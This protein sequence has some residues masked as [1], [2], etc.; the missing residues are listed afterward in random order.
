MPLA[1]SVAE[2]AHQ[3]GAHE[4]AHHAEED[5]EVEKEEKEEE[6]SISMV[7]NTTFLQQ[8]EGDR[9]QSSSSIGRP[10]KGWE[11][12]NDLG[13]EAAA[14]LASQN[15]YGSDYGDDY[16]EDNMDAMSAITEAPDYHDDSDAEDHI[17]E[18]TEEY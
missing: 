14:M 10:R 15:D 6:N 18:P 13:P 8:L 11:H 12:E 7:E 9:R 17:P 3:D 4:R 5:V 16:N 1:A 2:P